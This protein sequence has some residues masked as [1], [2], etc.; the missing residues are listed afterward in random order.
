[1]SATA[2][3]TLTRT[4]LRSNPGRAIALFEELLLT[5]CSST[6]E[7]E[8][9]LSWDA[10]PESGRR[11][12]AYTSHSPKGISLD[13]LN[14]LFCRDSSTT[15][16]RHHLLAGLA[17]S[18]RERGKEASKLLFDLLDNVGT[19]PDDTRKQQILD[20]LVSN[21]RKLPNTSDPV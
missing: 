19:Y 14:K 5:L 15:Q 12:I 7:R 8:I 9:L 21:I 18:C 2:W 1:M 13:L 4:D 6:L 16:N 10:M 11:N 3:L 20:N 17:V